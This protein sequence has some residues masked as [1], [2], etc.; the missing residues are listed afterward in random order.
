MPA[1]HR[2]D[3][4]GEAFRDCGFEVAEDQLQALQEMC[5]NAPAEFLRV[6]KTEA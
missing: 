5:A 2:I 6:I 3:Q 4:F 1:N